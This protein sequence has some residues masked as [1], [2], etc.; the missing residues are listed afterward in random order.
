MR[1]SVVTALGIQASALMVVSNESEK[2][3]KFKE[4]LLLVYNTKHSQLKQR[5]EGHLAKMTEASVY[6]PQRLR[7]P[8]LGTCGR[9]KYPATKI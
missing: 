6:Q 7:A 3:T 9:R 4:S 2:E 8:L 5:F 1:L